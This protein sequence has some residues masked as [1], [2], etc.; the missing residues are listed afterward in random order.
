MTRFKRL[1]L[2]VIN[3]LGCRCSNCGNSDWRVL[4]INHVNNDGHLLRNAKGRIIGLQEHHLSAILLGKDDISRYELLC[5]NCHV[6][7]TKGYI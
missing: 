2:E 6:L 3:L 1:R 4:E 5:A 7:R